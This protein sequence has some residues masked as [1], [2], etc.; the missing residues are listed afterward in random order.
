MKLE[1]NPN[2]LSQSI[3]LMLIM[4]N[5]IS[6]MEM[7]NDTLTNVEAILNDFIGGIEG[8][9]STATLSKQPVK[10]IK[11]ADCKPIQVLRQDIFELVC[12]LN[13]SVFTIKHDDIVKLNVLANSLKNE[14]IDGNFVHY[15]PTAI[16]DEK[17]T[18]VVEVDVKPRP[19]GPSTD[20]P[21]TDGPSTDGPRTDG[22]RTDEPDG[23]SLVIPSFVIPS[24]YELSLD[25]PSPAEPEDRFK[26]V[27]SLHQV[28]TVQPMTRFARELLVLRHQDEYDHTQTA[29]S[30]VHTEV[31]S[32]YRESWS[33]LIDLVASLLVTY[34][35][36]NGNLNRISCCNECGKLIFQNRVGCRNY[37]NMGCRVRH[38]QADEDPVQRKC[39]RRQNAWAQNQIKTGHPDFLLKNQCGN[40]FSDLPGGQCR[41]IKDR[42]EGRLKAD[43]Q[44]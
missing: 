44:A 26:E 4:F 24:P 7:D 42:N 6:L 13:G 10:P 19:D 34:H 40:C 15:I 43:K 39:R 2:E 18:R 14:I 32:C 27:V 11:T 22:P 38:N 12:Y 41:L 9:I 5:K 29:L 8:R 20:G 30:P 23:A 21:S 31:M 17:L 28:I 33:S 35:V 37:C 16:R 25:E 3:K 1:C 36:V